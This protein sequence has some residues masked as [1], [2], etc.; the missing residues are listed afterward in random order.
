MDTSS[1]EHTPAKAV[2]A[3]RDAPPSAGIPDALSSAA[4]IAVSSSSDIEMPMQQQS[5][6]QFNASSTHVSM[7]DN[8]AYQQQQQ[9]YQQNISN[10]HVSADPAL[11]MQAAQHV[12]DVQQQ[13]LHVTSEAHRAVTQTQAQAA[14]QVQ[15]TQA[16][17]ALAVQQTQVHAALQVQEAQHAV[18]QTQAQAAH[19][20]QEMQQQASQYVSTLEQQAHAAVAA[21]R[22]QAAEQARL[23]M[24][25][26]HA[27]INELQEQVLYLR[28]QASRSET[29]SPAVRAHSVGASPSVEGLEDLVARLE[30]LRRPN[31]VAAPIKRELNYNTPP[32]KQGGGATPL[33]GQ[34][35]AQEVR[36]V[37]PSQQ[38]LAPVQQQQQQ[39]WQ[40]Q[41]LGVPKGS[42]GPPQAYAPAYVPPFAEAHAPVQMQVQ[43]QS[44]CHFSAPAPVAPKAPMAPPSAAPA[45]MAA[46]APPMNMELL[47]QLQASISDRDMIIAQLMNQL[48]AAPAPKAPAATQPAASSKAAA[49]FPAF[50]GT[51]PFTNH[52][53]LSN[54]AAQLGGDGGDDGDGDDDDAGGENNPWGFWVPG[55]RERGSPGGGG[56]GGGGGGGGGDDYGGDSS[57]GD[58]PPY[59]EYFPVADED[60]YIRWKELS[61]ITIPDLPSS[62][63]DLRGWRNTVIVN[64]G[65]PDRSAHEVLAKWAL[66]AFRASGSIETVLARLQDSQGLHRLDK[67][68]GQL[69]LAKAASPNASFNTEFQGYVEWCQSVGEAP[70]GRVMIAMVA[71]KFRLDRKRGAVISQSTLLGI[72]LQG[73]KFAEMRD[74]VRRVE[75]VLGSMRRRELPSHDTMYQWLFEKVKGWRPI[76]RHIERVK[77]SP[78]RSRLRTWAFLWSRI[79]NALTEHY[80]DANQ[81]SIQNS[82]AGK[83]GLQD[84][85]GKKSGLPAKTGK[86][87]P[88]PPKGPKSEKQKEKAPKGPGKP[89]L[90]AKPE[91]KPPP[92]P[93]DGKAALPKISEMSA[94]QKA[95]VP[96][97][98]F[99]QNRCLQG[100]A[101]AFMHGDSGPAPKGPK[102]KG[103]RKAPSK[104]KAGKVA[105][106]VAAV[107]G[108][109]A[110]GRTVG[111]AMRRTVSCLPGLIKTLMIGSA[112][113]GSPS[114]SH[115][116]SARH[117]PDHPS[118]LPFTP[119]ESN[120]SVHALAA[121]NNGGD[122]FE[123]DIINDSGAG[124]P[125]GSANA[126]RAQGV[127][128][129]LL[130]RAIGPASASLTFETG[131]GDVNASDSLALRNRFMSGMY[132]ET[133]MLDQCPLAMSM[134]E[135]VNE[136]SMPFIWI[137]GELPYHVSDKSKVRVLCKERHK[138]RAHRVQDNV[139]I[140][141]ETMRITKCTHNTQA[142][143][144]PLACPAV[145]VPDEAHEVPSSDVFDP[146]ASAP[147]GVPGIADDADPPAPPEPHPEV[148]RRRR[149][150]GPEIP[151]PDIDEAPAPASAAE[152]SFLAKRKGM[153]KEELL[154]EAKSKLHSICHYPHNPFCDV[155]N[156]AHMKSARVHRQ[157]D[158]AADD[159][160]PPAKAFGHQLSTDT[161]IVSKSAGG[162]KAS[163]AGE[164]CCHT[165]RDSF[166]GMRLAYPQARRTK[167]SNYNNLKH[168][169]GLRL[170]RDPN[171]LVKSD[172][173][174]ELVEAVKELGWHAE[175]SLE[176]RWPHN[177]VHERDGGTLKATVRAALLASG[178]GEEGWS[179]GTPYGAVSLS[180]VQPAPIL[181][182]E[183]GTPVEHEKANLT[184]WAA[185]HG[186]DDFQGPMEPFGRLCFV[187]DKGQ[188]PMGA[189]AKPALF[190]GW[191]I[192]A[193][194]RY[195][196]VLLTLDFERVRT[197]SAGWLNVTSFPEKEVFFPE[198]VIFPI[199][200]AHK[201]QLEGRSSPNE[202]PAVAPITLP[203]AEDPK[204]PPPKAVENVSKKLPVFRIT[205][206]RLMEH[207]PTPDCD[208]CFEG[209]IVHT[210]AC[211]KRFFELIFGKE[212][213]AEA[214]DVPAPSSSSGGDP[215]PD[216]HEEPPAAELV[217][218]AALDD[219]L[220][221]SP[222]DD[223]AGPSASA[224]L[225][226]SLKDQLPR[227]VSFAPGK[228]CPEC[229][230]RT[231]GVC[232][233]PN[234]MSKAD[235]THAPPASPAT[236]A[237][238]TTPCPEVSSSSSAPSPATKA[239]KRFGMLCKKGYLA[240][241]EAVD[242][243]VCEAA[244]FYPD[245]SER[246][247]LFLAAAERIS[248][249][250]ASSAPQSYPESDPR[251]D[252]KH[253][254][255]M[256]GYGML[257]EVACDANS[258]LGRVASRYKRVHVIRVTQ[259]HDLA[260]ENTVLQLLEHIRAHPGM[261]IHGSIPC[262]PW[263]IWQNMSISRLGAAYLA[264]LER[265]RAHSMLLFS[266]FRRLADECVRLGGRASFEWPKSCSGWAQHDVLKF[267]FDH[268]LYTAECHGCAFGLKS[269]RGHP[270][271][272]PWRIVTSDLMLA[273]NLAQFKCSHPKQFK[274][275]HAQGGETA[276]TAFYPESMCEAMLCSLYPDLTSSPVP[277]MPFAK[278]RSQEQQ[279]RQKELTTT[280]SGIPFCDGRT[281]SAG[282]SLFGLVTRLLD[283]REMLASPK[284]L[285]AVR[286]EAQ[287]LESAG[288]WD[289][290]TVVEKDH[291]IAQAKSGNETVHLGELMSIC[292]EKFS[293]M[294]EEHRRLKGRVVFRGDITKDQDG[295]LAVF[296]E[297]GASPTSIHSAN[298]NLAYGMIPG[299][300]TT[301]AD[302]I[303]AYIQSTLKS[304]HKTWVAL[305]R[306]LWP[307]DW[308]Q[309][310]FRKPMVRLIKSLYGH[311]EA[312]GHWEARLTEVVKSL[313]GE[314]I[315]EHPSSFWFPKTQMLL[316][317]YVDDLLLSGPVA[318]HD[319]FWESLGKHIDIEPPQELERFLG[320]HHDVV[321]H[322]G[323][324]ALAF[325]MQDYVGQAVDKYQ[326]VSGVTKLKHAPTP[327]VPDGSLLASDDEEA[328]ELASAACSILMKDLWLARL[329]RPETMK[330]I[331]D[332]ASKVQC[333]TKNHDKMLHRLMCY[334]NST[335]EYRLVGKVRDPPEALW[336]RLYVDAD[337]GGDRSDVKSTN[338]GY[339][340]LCGPNTFFPLAW[341]AKRQTSTSRSTTESEV[342]SMAY[343]LFSEALP[344]LQL[345]ETILG[346]SVELE[347]MEDNEATIRIVLKGY[348]AKLRHVQRT[349]KINISSIKEV[350]DKENV[351]VKYCNTDDQ[352]A[353][354]FTKALAPQKWA[355]ALYLLGMVTEPLKVLRAG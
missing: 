69:M 168:F 201:L 146:I 203:W 238:T 197:K 266:N 272:K 123:V 127:P 156:I 342:V 247:A 110:E 77:D 98:F 172:A 171:V 307:A 231:R 36:E 86:Q 298:S 54:L 219:D 53:T 205:H 142:A 61:G 105:G 347:I 7:Q 287:G 199:A 150:K 312:G 185:A 223:E 155:C 306:E 188:H 13:A 232:C 262:G 75:Y 331:C 138:L 162:A 38:L 143:T 79:K 209:K 259:H 40:P 242:S 125:I 81:A 89:A 113:F 290:S 48:Q 4:A 132:S 68:L 190:A 291:L 274:H 327:F 237:I 295:S 299:H 182:H 177:A 22:A 163:A 317:V 235:S 212:A 41:D 17:A 15:Q 244:A 267:I 6:Q 129:A 261:D 230:E 328:G 145:E 227:K 286:E 243:A 158:S 73:Y 210:P 166:S 293:E 337:F 19:R 224:L 78:S 319:R 64:I 252:I 271:L 139:P 248:S 314:P 289:L 58:I 107:L 131:D 220:E 44:Q 88:P 288:T 292:S 72:Q 106:A 340:V 303:K 8:Q 87:E 173:A 241:V 218:A 285:E 165:I 335:P 176:N 161:L 281:L 122:N 42:V 80:E 296:Q 229:L 85:G 309:K 184:C 14:M 20:V 31:P 51:D 268:N 39:P 308:K 32:A 121:P 47:Q 46:G 99:A 18:S 279:H 192:E 95:K 160:L 206:N 92:P 305:P 339:L 23:A 178:I 195:R 157:P 234:S 226:K 189:N 49:Q 249:T 116:P 228:F 301:Q 50:P 196:G 186:G 200:N 119:C 352:A 148:R 204:P 153:S 90:P 164:V 35:P 300:K 57:D 324:P 258:T 96:C 135:I 310:G 318:N 2:V 136:N 55:A 269:R 109:G 202:V 30:A 134:G 233:A 179:V 334:L 76:E 217:S 264:K 102:G 354:I 332:L 344:A 101:C 144:N 321:E 322:D 256:V 152:G 263:S 330:A 260:N 174:G 284:A 313:G 29:A 193:G 151:R 222:T 294:A 250:R 60:D 326:S 111:S 28:E 62:A 94:A 33:Q 128:S 71:I 245:E 265:K 275:D 343:S 325:N 215:V 141:R 273:Q 56:D 348:S 316:T 108:V 302:A 16:Q 221:Y 70:K 329:A 117:A 130:S 27:K 83:A 297:L 349:H 59:D 315:Y 10:V 320:R 283:R 211:R 253:Q 236:T 45:P 345:W 147:L 104:P 187:R 124:K 225:A 213:A 311:P 37:A 149:S 191:R 181:P 240:G 207:G 257:L 323:G 346:R 100:T 254:K 270:M 170:Q 5:F 65:A 82:L 9:N 93:K 198:E 26:A 103:T 12:H 21:E 255:G 137:P 74:F 351:A 350:V 11:V 338:G 1:S 280:D 341:V 115:L 183:V 194:C 276:R 84:G 154:A 216:A 175:P 25:E 278:Q 353:D 34:V 208:A 304:K 120:F 91:L 118:P 43:P 114:T 24:A 167:D 66:Q 126:L 239:A 214:F 159:E 97:M 140:F 277:A 246:K 3:T 333:W 67:H 133:Y 355:H 169:A 112:M 282:N 63:A 251:A 336:L 180:A 52:P